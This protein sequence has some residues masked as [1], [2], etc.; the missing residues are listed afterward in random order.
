[1]GKRLKI[2]LKNVRRKVFKPYLKIVFMRPIAFYQRRFS[3][4]TCLYQPTCS[5]YMKR[6]INNKGVFLGLLLGGW[7]LLRCNPFSKGGYDPAPEKY[8]KLKWVL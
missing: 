7:R 2:C 6:C 3:K 1:M 8:Y 5:E 4:H